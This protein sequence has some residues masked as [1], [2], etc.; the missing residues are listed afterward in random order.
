[1]GQSAVGQSAT[2]ETALKRIE[3]LAAY[4]ADGAGQSLPKR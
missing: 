4:D 3:G 1:M 2:L